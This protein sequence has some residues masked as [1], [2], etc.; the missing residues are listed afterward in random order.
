MHHL[1]YD[2]GV[3]RSQLRKETDYETRFYCATGI[4]ILREEVWVNSRE[5]VV[6]YNL[7]LI[8]PGR[9]GVDNG[10]VLGYDNAHGM[11]E[12]HFEGTVEPVAFSS[13]RTTSTRFFAE[14]EALR[15]TL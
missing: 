13:Y 14:A 5:E 7:A 12:R 6:E 2:L 8:L 4:G 9:S 15:R 10:R 3:G 1:L 11:H